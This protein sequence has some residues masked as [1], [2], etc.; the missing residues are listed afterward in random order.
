MRGSKNA[1]PVLDLLSARARAGHRAAAKVRIVCCCQVSSLQCDRGNVCW[2]QTGHTDNEGHWS[3]H[4]S[5]GGNGFLKLRLGRSVAV[6]CVLFFM[7]TLCS[8]AGLRRKFHAFFTS[9]KYRSKL[10][11]ERGRM[12][13]VNPG[14][15]I[16]IQ[17]KTR[18]KGLGLGAVNSSHLDHAPPSRKRS[19]FEENVCV[20]VFRAWL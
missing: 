8:E 16:R 13:A 17:S 10:T 20:Y 18:I 12:M 7:P 15:S 3:P 19:N 6:T 5:G 9:S 2:G 4:E 14:N 11:A 1:Y